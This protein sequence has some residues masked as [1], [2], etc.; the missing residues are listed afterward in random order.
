MNGR[1]VTEAHRFQQVHQALCWETS[2]AQRVD[3]LG[4][5]VRRSTPWRAHVLYKCVHAHV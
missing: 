1:G 2:R 3:R 5:R 4:N